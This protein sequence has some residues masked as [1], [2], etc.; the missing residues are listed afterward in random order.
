MKTP[1]KIHYLLTALFIALIRNPGYSQN[2]DAYKYNETFYPDKNTVTTSSQFNGYTNYWHDIYREKISYGNLF[3]CAIPNINYTIAQ[4]KLDIADDMNIPGLSLQEGFIYNLFKGLYVTLDQPTVQKLT[5]ATVNNNVLVITDPDSETGKKLADKFPGDNVWKE[6]LKSHQFN[7][8]DF[9]GINAYYLENGSKKIFVISS[10]SKE[11]RDKLIDV[12]NNTKIILDKFDL[13]RGW[14]GAETLLKSV[15]CTPGH[16]LEVIGKGMNEG[17][18]WFTFSGYM[19]FLEQKELTNWLAKVNLPVVAD[20][21]YGQIYGLNNYDGLQVQSMTT[22][23]SWVNFA[24]EKGGYVFRSV[25]NDKAN[26][27]HYDGYFAVEGYKRTIDKENV[28]F[29]T[30][31]GGLYNDAVPCMVLFIRKGEQITRQLMW[32]SIMDRRE[33]AVIENGKM[34]GPALYRNSLETLLLDRIFLEEYFGDRVNI[35]ASTGNYTLNVNLTNTY[36]HAVSGPLDIVLP[37]ELNIKGSKSMT[38]SL[39][40]NSSKTV[41]FELQP[42]ASAMNKTNPIAVHYK[43]ETSKKSTL[44][45]LNLPRVISVQQLLFGHTPKVT[46]PVTIHNFT[47]KTSFPVKVE[48]LDKNNPKK[49]VYSTSK[50]CNAATGSFGEMS[51]DLEVP[52]GGYK[53]KVSALGVENLSQLGVE[54]ASGA[55]MLYEID[56]N[57]DGVNEYRMENDSVQV[58]LL[59][60]GAR[61][62]EYIVKSKNDNVFFKL[63]PEKASDDKRLFRYRGYYPYGGFEDFLGQGSMETHKV[64]D[65]EITRKEGDYVQVKMTTDFFG[66]K[67][68]KIFTLYGNSPLLEVQF[69][70]TFINP[71]ANVIGPQPILEL[72]EK[73]GT[74]DVFTI[75]EK[76]GL[77]EYRMKMEDYYGRLFFLKEGWNAGCDTKQN[78]SFV[79]AYPVTEPMFLHMWMNHPRNS[80][81]HY[82]YVELQPWIPIYQK[83]V[84]YFSYYMWATGGP[85]EKGVKALRDRNL[86]TEQ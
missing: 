29:V 74:E 72:G 62:I 75:P 11:L 73:H 66:N 18:T 64:Y 27:Y 49:V 19:E 85:W 69:A 82:Y 47:D 35:E 39:P 20:V 67:L 7:A 41:K 61:V 24:H 60:T 56:L 76:D 22:D 53:I 71:E 34:M 45:I 84:M 25:D 17:N 4:S 3:K 28:P 36:A 31:T 86:I 83:S 59:R 12:L 37:P 5:E 42:S 48:V 14:F 9:T 70:L 30:T 77:H 26:L 23:E 8:K 55:P 68:Q 10:K 38:V 15:T 50:T 21:G 79:G 13:H 44:T 54:T 58:T 51:F 63:W 2:L 16:P 81:A 65:A 52:A 46:Y 57:N 33:V 80:E 40:A 43:W 78:I 6:T 32:E 1:M